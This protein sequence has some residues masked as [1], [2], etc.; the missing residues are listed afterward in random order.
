MFRKQQTDYLK[1]ILLKLLL[2]LLLICFGVTT[3]GRV[4]IEEYKHE[5]EATHENKLFINSLLCRLVKF[6]FVNVMLHRSFY[7]LFVTL[8]FRRELI[9]AG[10]EM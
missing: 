10:S 3:V 4:I 1:T 2:F 9:K 6:A 8:F 7:Y 5:I